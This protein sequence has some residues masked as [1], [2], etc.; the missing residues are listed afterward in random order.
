MGRFDLVSKQEVWLR[1]IQRF[2][3]SRLT[4]AEFCDREQV[5]VAA[6]YQWR[7]KL[8]GN[9]KPRQQS[10]VQRPAFAPVRLV[11]S[12]RAAEP[13]VTVQLPGGTRLKIPLSD[14]AAF[15]RAIRVL[16]QA[17]AQRRE[18]APC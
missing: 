14:G 5:S 6:F 16:V 1:R 9:L 4:V 18:G 12:S 10:P 7:R 3:Q 13:V 2:S 11:T 17:D 8:G 15:E